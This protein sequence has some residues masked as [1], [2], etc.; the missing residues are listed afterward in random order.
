MPGIYA[1]RTHGREANGVQTVPGKGWNALIR[2]SGSLE[3]W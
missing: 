3:P 2:L 1:E